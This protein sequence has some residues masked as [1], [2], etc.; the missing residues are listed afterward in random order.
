MQL[1]ACGVVV[2]SVVLSS[3]AAAEAPA[4]RPV[5][6]A[7][8]SDAPASDTTTAASPMLLRPPSAQ[9]LVL[10]DDGAARARGDA[11]SPRAHDDGRIIGQ[12]L[13]GGV[14]ALGGLVVGG[15]V[16]YG[17]D[18]D[19]DGSWYDGLGGFLLGAAIGT[20]SLTTAAV[21]V[22][23]AEDGHTGSVAGTALGATIGAGAGLL[24]A[25]KLGGGAASVTGFCLTTAAS[26]T[27]F[28][29]LTRSH[30]H[31]RSA[32]VVAP[33]YAPNTVGIALVGALP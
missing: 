19:D 4:D 30:D 9:R 3:V 26:A 22:V 5:S 7:P 11:P 16:G 14:G 23:G 18:R 13:I 33:M 25:A 32:V 21:M 2:T 24:V 10:P 8:A 6:D 27:M 28:H 17:L 15:L 29:R 1:R 12:V 20:T 31:E